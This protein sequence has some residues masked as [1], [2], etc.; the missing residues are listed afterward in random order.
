MAFVSDICILPSGRSMTP[1]L[2][3]LELT[4]LKR[5]IEKEMRG[6]ERG[7]GPGEKEVGVVE[8]DWLF[9]ISDDPFLLICQLYGDFRLI[10]SPSAEVMTFF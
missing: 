5:G 1:T 10:F 7:G 8:G 4:N 6:L 2:S 9:K 3:V